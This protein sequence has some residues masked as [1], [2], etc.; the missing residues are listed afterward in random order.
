MAFATFGLYTGNTSVA[1][2]AT[3][4]GDALRSS[5]AIW[6]RDSPPTRLKLPT[7]TKVDPSGLTS[8]SGT[9]IEPRGGLVNGM[10]SPGSTVPLDGFSLASPDRALPLIVVNLPPAYSQPSRT[11]SSWTREPAFAVKPDSTCPVA[12]VI[13][14]MRRLAAPSTVVNAPPMKT[15]VPPGAT[16]IASTAPFSTTSKSGSIAPVVVSTANR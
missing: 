11:T 9:R 15:E 4:T 5:I 8:S 14:A 13:R 12:M 10:S 3:V 2:L 16:A 6:T 1:Q 7:A